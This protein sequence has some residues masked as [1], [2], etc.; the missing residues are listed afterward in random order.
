MRGRILILSTLLAWPTILAAQGLDT[1]KIDEAMGRSGQKTGDVY[2]LGFPRTDLHVSIAG[3]EIKP[4]LALGPSAA[5]SD[6]DTDSV[7]MGDLLLLQHE[8][9]PVM[10]KLRVAAFDIAPAH[11]H[12]L[13]DTTR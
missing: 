7:V 4:A 2:R 3:V 13:N 6:N 9:I 10:Q 5:F 1:A 12:I 11:N 8:L